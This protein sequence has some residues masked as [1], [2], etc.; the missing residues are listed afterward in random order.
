LGLESSVKTTSSAAGRISQRLVTFEHYPTTGLVKIARH[1]PDKGP[2][3]R[4]L[5]R[6]FYDASGLLTD[7]QEVSADEV[8]LS[9]VQYDASEG[10]FPIAIT[11]PMGHVFRAVHHPA[12]G[13]P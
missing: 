12:F 8:R 2:E 10:M 5:T 9:S 13:V 11:N 7:T 3:L 6:Y 4:L 1:A